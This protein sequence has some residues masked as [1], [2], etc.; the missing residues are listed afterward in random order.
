MIYL[1]LIQKVKGT[2]LHFVAVLSS[3]RLEK[4]GVF[5]SLKASLGDNL[6]FPHP[7]SIVIG[8]GVYIGSDVTIYQS[9]TL[10]GRVIGDRKKGNYPTIGDGTVIFAGAVIVGK[11]NIGKNCVIGANSV[12]ISDLPDNSVAVGAPARVVKILDTSKSV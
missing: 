2:K 11:V 7:T 10:G 1:R 5:I 9:V 12:V 3:R 6:R 4:Y 8:E